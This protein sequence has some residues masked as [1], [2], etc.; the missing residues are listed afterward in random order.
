MLCEWTSPNYK[1]LTD[2]T[3]ALNTYKA[4]L[5]SKLDAFV[6]DNMEAPA[7]GLEA[8]KANWQVSL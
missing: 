6:R 5:N 1:A 3:T 7:A 2:Y 8:I 4:P